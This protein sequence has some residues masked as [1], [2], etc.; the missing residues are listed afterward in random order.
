MCHSQKIEY[1][2]ITNAQNLMQFGGQQRGCQ[3][4]KLLR[5]KKGVVLNDH[6]YLRVTN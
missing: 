4:V 5:I 6:N 3:F 1:A 2:I